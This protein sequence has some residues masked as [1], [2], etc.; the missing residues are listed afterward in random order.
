M[1]ESFLI[2]LL[3]SL[4][5][6]KCSLAPFPTAAYGAIRQTDKLQDVLIMG[7]EKISILST[8]LNFQRHGALKKKE[9]KVHIRPIGGLLRL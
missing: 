4:Y 2:G 7:Y 1:V 3:P 6:L 8:V 5:L 9:M